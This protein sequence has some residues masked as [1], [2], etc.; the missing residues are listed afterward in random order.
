MPITTA[1][2]PG[3]FCWW[4]LVTPDLESSF[5]YYRRLFG[6]TRRDASGGEGRRYRTL[7]VHGEPLGAVSQTSRDQIARGEQGGWLC[8]V[9][10]EDADAAAQRIL[11]AGGGLVQRPFDVFEAGRMTV[12]A[13]PTGA[14]AA[15]WQPRAHSGAAIVGE[16][17]SATWSELGTSD[18]GAARAFYKQVFGWEAEPKPGPT[19]YTEWRFEDGV[20]AGGMYRLG[21]EMGPIPSYWGV[22][23]RVADCDDTVQGSNQAGG[24]T[25]V[26]PT[27]LPGGGRFAMLNDP[28][29]A[30]FGVVELARG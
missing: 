16:L 17:G 28:A 10:I 24:T 11:S 30:M 2:R 8:Y 1:H 6:W 25:V 23:F 4:E 9:A 19:S 3:S 18:P 22:Y 26:P 15:L 14:R 29:G 21:S 5:T 13:D 20:R 12:F 27:E 7:E